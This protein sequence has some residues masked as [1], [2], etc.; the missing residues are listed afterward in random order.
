MESVQSVTIEQINMNEA[1]RYL[2]IRSEEPD[3]R[4]K[5]LLL[6]CE[7]ELLQVL[8]GKFVYKVFPLVN[9]QIPNCTFTL[10]GKAIQKHLEGC[11][12]V[13]LLCAT[14][15]SGV[16][17][18]I[19]KKQIM[20]MAEAMMIDSMASVAV[21]QV[22]DKAE[23]MVLKDFPGMEHTWRFGLGYGDFPLSGQ[24]DFLALLDAPKRVGVCVNGASMLTP[25]KSV[26]CVIGIGKNLNVESI[27]SCD[28]CNMREQCQ[29]R[30][31][32]KNCGK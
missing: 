24:K 14:V 25:T 27:Q 22:C 31:E 32:G 10:Q 20:G 16:D 9:G 18:L 2:G 6:L 26:T 23:E 3:H 19:R 21:E 15:S 17:A 12:Q 4:T 28:F 7:K 29:F 1:L 8:D 5:E 13:I 30:K 11:E